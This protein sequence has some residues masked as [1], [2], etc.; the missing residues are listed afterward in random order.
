MESLL[1]PENKDKLTA[2]LTY[3][4]VAGKVTAAQVVKLKTADTVNGKA[5]TIK[6]GKDGVMVNN[7]KVSATD[8]PASNGVIP[9]IDTVLIP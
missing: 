6:A 5:L 3:H 9:V 2:I 1:K 4:V 7:A 8:I